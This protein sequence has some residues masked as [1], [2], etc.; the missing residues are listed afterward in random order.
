MKIKYKQYY[1]V[2]IVFFL[3][4]RNPG[5]ICIKRTV[6]LEGYVCRVLSRNAAL[7]RELYS[8]TPWQYCQQYC[9][10]LSLLGREY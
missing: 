7:C 2:D 8:A 5:D 4:L 1:K 3:L 6:L 9:N 10:T